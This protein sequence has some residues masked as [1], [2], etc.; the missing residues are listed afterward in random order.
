MQK[1]IYP[2]VLI[3]GESFHLMSGG[4]ITLVS[5]F[6]DWPRQNLAVVVKRNKYMLFEYCSNYY[7]LGY[8]EEKR[9]WP[10]H[11]FQKKNESGPIKENDW[12]SK[13][14][15]HAFPPE[16][17]GQKSKV[18]SL[19]IQFLHFLGLYPVIYRSK[20]SEKYIQWLDEFHPDIV[21]TQLSSIN[22]MKFVKQT[23]EKRNIPLAI[24]IMDDWPKTLKEPGILYFYWKKVIEN[25][26]KELL[27][28]SSV[29]MSICSAMSEEYMARYGIKFIPFHNSVDL[30]KWR[31]ISKTDWTC[32]Q[33]FTILYAGRIGIGVQES[34]LMIARAVEILAENGYSIHFKIRS[35][36]FPGDFKTK[37]NNFH[38]TKIEGYLSNNEM[39]KELAGA[40]LLVLP[41]DFNK[42]EFT[43]LSM[44]TKV[45]E[46]LISGTP[47]LVIAHR[48]TALYRYA[49]KYGWGLTV[50]EN[51]VEKITEKIK[52]FYKNHKLRQMYG[53]TGK[54]I[55]SKYHNGEMIRKDFVLTLKDAIYN[56]QPMTHVQ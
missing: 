38:H 8:L 53:E 4:G 15:I 43:R 47:I 55:A 7:G 5:L 6:K 16:N 28:Y 40:D 46:Y 20:V 22:M 32:N 27:D 44:P 21:Y 45:P 1:N 14:S 24:H 9:C 3:I 51:E 30:S 2:R 12:I 56:S 11:Y 17:I 23:I 13:Q 48:E 26:F 49:K 10:F 18:K 41:L 29:R 35:G 36:S 31:N 33:V 52:L 25:K 54:K 37:L 39:P 19:F 34:V 42:L 50:S